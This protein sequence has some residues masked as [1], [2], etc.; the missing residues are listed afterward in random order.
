[1]AKWIAS[2]HVVEATY[3]DFGT[4]AVRRGHNPLTAAALATALR[5]TQAGRERAPVGDVPAWS[6]RTTLRKHAER[7]GYRDR[8][9]AVKEDTVPEFPGVTH[10]A[11]TVTDLGRSRPWYEEPL[12]QPAGHR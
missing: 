12:R 4:S 9:R 6:Q 7:E 1:M 11:L 5:R 8:Q 10:V 2:H 3:W